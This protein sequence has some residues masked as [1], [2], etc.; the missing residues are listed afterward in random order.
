M[1]RILLVEDNPR[2][3]A[4]AMRFLT[5][6]EVL[7]AVNG[8]EGVTKARETKPDLILMD[9]TLPVKDGYQATRELKDDGETKAI[10]VIAFTARAMPHEEKAAWDA[11][12]DDFESRP[13]EWDR[14]L[15]KIKMLLDE[16]APS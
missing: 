13:V 15:E 9:M 4:L 5:D 3:V 1:A 11:G 10:P 14:L 7:V 12:C 16:K 2:N 6:Y 8:D